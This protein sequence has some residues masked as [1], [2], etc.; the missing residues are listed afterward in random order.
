MIFKNKCGKIFFPSDFSGI[1]SAD[2]IRSSM[3]RLEGDHVLKRL[4]HGI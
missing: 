2:A 3:H 4:A 1:G